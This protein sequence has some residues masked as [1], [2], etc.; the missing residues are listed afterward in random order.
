MRMVMW[1]KQLRID[2]TE[3]NLPVEGLVHLTQAQLATRHHSN[4]TRSSCD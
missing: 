2:I 3:G 4:H 1:N